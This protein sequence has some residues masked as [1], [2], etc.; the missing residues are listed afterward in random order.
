[1][2]L[3]LIALQTAMAVGDIIDLKEDAELRRLK[4]KV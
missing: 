4:Q 2:N 3:V 1:M